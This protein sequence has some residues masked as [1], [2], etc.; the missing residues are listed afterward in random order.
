MRKTL[1]TTLG[2]LASISLLS[3]CG[4]STEASE[5]KVLD[6][7]VGEWHQINADEVGVDMVATVNPASIQID[8]KTREGSH[9]VYWLGTF[10]TDQDLSKKIDIVSNADSD[11]QM[12]MDASIFGSQSKTKQFTY[13]NGELTFEFTIMRTTSTVRLQK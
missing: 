4:G 2:I 9:S 8:V 11:A 3:A 10:E 7:L 13:E 1:L 5:M 12:Q 6:S